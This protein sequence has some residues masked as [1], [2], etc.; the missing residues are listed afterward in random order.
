MD[1]TILPLWQPAFEHSRYF[2]NQL[3]ARPE[4]IPE[5]LATWQ[6]P[7]SEDMLLAPL[8]GP[9]ADDDAV[10]SSL[11]RL[12]Q[13]VMTHLALRDLCGLAPLSE[14]V[15]SMTM[16]A[17][18][19]TNFA[20]D[21]YHRQ[22]VATYGEPLDKAGQPLRMLV[23]GMGKLGGRELNVSS[24]VDYIFIYP[25]D[26]D[27]AGPKSIENYD[28]FNRLGKRVIQALG[29]ITADGQVFRVDMRLRPNGDS[30]PLVCSL[31]SLENY[32]ITQGREWERYA[33]IKGRTMNS[34]DNLQ[35]A[36]VAAM[37]KIARPFVFRKY[38]DFGAINAMRDLHAQI[39]REVARKDMA[40]HVKLGPGGIREIEFMAQVFQLIRGGRDPALQIRPTLSVLKLLVER[41]LLPAESEQEL[42][43]AYIFLRRLEH[44]LQ[45]V[46][47]KQTHML[48]ETPEGRTSIARSMNF[49]DWEAMLLV[50]N[51]HRDK[52]S[53][54]FE[55]IFSDPEAGEHPL[56]G[57][58][59]GQIDEE[60]AI[61]AFGNLGFRQPREAIARLGE[62]RTSG[63]YQQLPASN[64]SRLD[65]VGPRLIEAAGATAAPD[66]TLT[67]GLSFLENIARRGSYL[68]LLQQYPMALRRVAD[69]I[70]ASSWAADYLNRHPLLLDELLD[71]RLYDI[72][73]DWAAFRDNLQRSLA[74]NV[75]DTEREMDILR[76]MHH[77]QIF[78][79]LAQDLAGLQTIE[80]LSDHLTELADAIVQ[81]TLPLC[82]SK[83][84]NRH[85]ATPKF[86]VIGYGKMG[87]KE[88]GYA[89]DLDLVYLFE[90]DAQEAEENY[91]RLGQR[92]NTWLS[93]Q[94]SAGILFETDLRLRPNGDSG[95]LA[96]SVDSFRDY[97]LKHAWVWEHQALTR[98]RFVAGDPAVGARFE[99]IRNEILCQPRD[100]AKLREEVIAMRDKMLDAHAS[101]SDTE[102][103]LKHDRGGIVDVEF[104]VQYLVLGYAS[105][106]NELTGN[107]GNIALLRIAAELGLIP[108]AL[109]AAAGNAYREYRRLQHAR[110]LTATPKARVERDSIEK[111]ATAVDQL[112]QAVFAS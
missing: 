12:R 37:Q 96:V 93:S 86:A 100:L 98:A 65:A 16:L 18:I 50:L 66:T 51:A 1:H 107:L 35:P 58:W 14:I 94:T 111:H 99:A 13:R 30:G 88:L 43:E 70:C 75:D 36:W 106:H 47:D 41:K 3:R 57:L 6:Q 53:R 8:R 77:A 33:W 10:K 4:L 25:E 79:L 105:Q 26:G 85:C 72:A 22:F 24:D 73:T 23:I 71:P 34:G 64:R 27:T 112:W 48:P 7:L 2:A 29:D 87:G 15:E 42:R 90:D 28:F 76:E 84:R 103:D 78:R 82:W 49:A 46:E 59:M 54:H 92:L 95:L 62:L 102:F 89:S 60:T 40:D 109:A 17:D 110:R 45:Y 38:L 19:T 68:A 69:M 83:V 101:N 104:I 74:D 20:L 44:R 97:Q 55:E 80:H 56:T 11:R 31:D 32:F 21:H 91:T 5:L 63:R 108:A 81:E 61:E 39:R 67:R 9:F 52:V